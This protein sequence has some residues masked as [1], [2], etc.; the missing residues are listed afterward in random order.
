M[1][2]HSASKLCVSA[3]SNPQLITRAVTRNSLGRATSR[4]IILAAE[5]DCC[6]GGDGGESGR[7]GEE[8]ICELY[9][10]VG[11]WGWGLGLCVMVLSGKVD[12]EVELM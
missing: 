2:L 6:V 8:S 7:E 1:P 5:G 9:F 4:A 3:L 10:L 12:I 11:W